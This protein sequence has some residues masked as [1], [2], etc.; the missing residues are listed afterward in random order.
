[1]ASPRVLFLIGW[2]CATVAPGAAA[3]EFWLPARLDSLQ[4][5]ARADSNDPLAHHLVGLA[6]W[7]QRRFDLAESAFR[8]ALVVDP[9]YA[10]AHLALGLI[11]LERY[12]EL[13]PQPAGRKPRKIRADV[14]EVGKRAEASYRMA[15]LL[16]PLVTLEAPG[17]PPDTTGRALW[18][19]FHDTR[20]GA[21]AAFWAYF[22]GDFQQAFDLCQWI[23]EQHE[24]FQVPGPIPSQVL[25]LHGLSGAKLRRFE[26]GIRALVVLVERSERAEAAD[27][28]HPLMFLATNDLRYMLADFRARAGHTWSAVQTLRLVLVHDLGAWMAHV[29]LAGLHEADR[30]FDEALAE[31]REATLLKPD[32]P[33]LWLDLGLTLA[34]SG[35]L[36]AADSVLAEVESALPRYPMGAYYRGEV[37]WY[38]GDR[39]AAR[40]AYLRFLALA[41]SRLAREIAEATTRLE[42]LR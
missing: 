12:P 33:T 22:R 28:A 35:Q 30:R 29:R 8:E 2:V 21:V 6:R 10:P 15:F 14:V 41:P 1:M 19:G 27:S 11:A 18:L 16:D 39:D 3:Q 24:T 40:E 38:R 42:F 37:A 34:R 25:W 36:E 5:L 13:R 26:P 32:D 31:R 23:V 7:N 9:R 17:T 4:A 20:L